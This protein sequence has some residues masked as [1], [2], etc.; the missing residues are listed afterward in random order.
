[1]E[2]FKDSVGYYFIG[3]K[4]F[5]QYVKNGKQILRIEPSK[6]YINNIQR[7][8]LYKKDYRYFISKIF[9]IEIIGLDKN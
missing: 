5:Y 2:F 8:T 1:M 7:Y 3:K 6:T 9:E 4:L